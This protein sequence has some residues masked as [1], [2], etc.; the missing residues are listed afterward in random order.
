MFQPVVFSAVIK[1]SDQPFSQRGKGRR[2]I[3]VL[4]LT[5]PQPSGGDGIQADNREN[6]RFYPP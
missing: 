1:I 3:I 5:M 4:H 2:N 6:N